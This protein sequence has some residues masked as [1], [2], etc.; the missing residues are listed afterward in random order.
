MDSAG[1]PLSLTQTAGAATS[2]R[3]GSNGTSLARRVYDS[4]ATRCVR[5]EKRQ[6]RVCDSAAVKGDMSRWTWLGG[7]LLP[8][9]SA[10]AAAGEACIVHWLLFAP[11]APHHWN[12]KIVY[13]LAW[14]AFFHRIHH[15]GTRVLF[16]SGVDLFP[17]GCS[18]RPCYSVVP[19]DRQG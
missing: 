4:A 1:S 3:L 10:L 2:G 8:R 6:S 16:T 12:T 9:A 15:A 13:N 7:R 17:R 11:K 18:G 14:A 5:P 19:N